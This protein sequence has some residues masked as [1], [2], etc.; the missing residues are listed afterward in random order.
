MY[1]YGFEQT[2]TAN[3]ATSDTSAQSAA[4]GLASSGVFYVRLCADTD[5]YYAVGSN[6]TATTS[7]TFLPANTIEI[8]KVPVGDKVAG[9]L[10]TGTGIL[11]VTVLTSQWLIDLELMG[12]FIL[13]KL[14]KKDQVVMRS[15]ILNAYRREKKLEVKVK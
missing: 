15:R 9:I 1:N 7:S 11:G 10:A 4:L 13:S 14:E 3:V 2:S 6:P 12:M 8:I 5:T